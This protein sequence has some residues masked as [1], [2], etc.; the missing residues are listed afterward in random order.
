MILP[1]IPDKKMVYYIARTYYPQLLR[2]G[3]H[4]YE[5]TPGFIHAKVFTADDRRATVGTIN[6]DYRSL[7]H[8]FEDAVYFYKHD[9][10]KTVED[11]FQNTLK[12]CMEV[13]EEYYKKIPLYQKSIGRIT[14]LIAPLL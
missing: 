11:D 3:I 13:T 8:H 7:Y 2:A 4:V 1:H 5:Y 9:V 6:L 14:K 12:D 10:V